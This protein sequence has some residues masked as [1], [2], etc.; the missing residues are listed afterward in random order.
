MDNKTVVRKGLAI[1]RFCSVFLYYLS[2][3]LLQMDLNHDW[4]ST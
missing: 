1:M 2:F 3:K 4:S